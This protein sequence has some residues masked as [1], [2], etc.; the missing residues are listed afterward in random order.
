MRPVTAY[1][2]DDGELFRTPDKAKRQDEA[3]LAKPLVPIL[4]RCLSRAKEAGLGEEYGVLAFIRE[5]AAAV[6][7]FLP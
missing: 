6:R 7:S 2:S 5:N 3:C 4:H 1:E